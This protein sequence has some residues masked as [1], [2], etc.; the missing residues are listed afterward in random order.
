MKKIKIIV[1]DDSLF[2]RK[3]ISELIN[4]DKECEVIASASNGLDALKLVSVLKPDVVCLDIELPKMDGITTLKYIMSEW[5]TPVIMVTGYKEY[6]GEETIKCLEYGA[7]DVVYKPTG[8]AFFEIKKLKNNL[9][10]KIKIA[11]KAN[12]ASL[13]PV[14]ND[15]RVKRKIKD[16]K[17][18]EKVVVI[19]C[20]TGGPRAL[21]HIL[22]KIKADINSA[23]VVIQHMPKGFT[24]SLADRLNLVSA[25]NVSEAVSNRSLKGGE[26]YIV[27]GSQNLTLEKIQEKVIIK[28]NKCEK[29]HGVCP[30]ANVSMDS[31]AEIYKDKCLGVILTGMGCDGVKGV[32]KIYKYGGKTIAEDSSTCIVFGMPKAAIQAG[33]VSEIM[34]LGDI[35]LAINDWAKNNG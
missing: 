14:I 25:V 32:T 34:P 28:L 1:V 10:E 15:K 21:S 3:S 4:S 12:I 27:P 2:M 16:K 23:I 24:K 19:A 30:S 7:V 17:E 26:V 11:A 29:S 8:S 33:V 35:A 5:P 6:F 20:S 13:K 31:I 9:I 18:V 22:P